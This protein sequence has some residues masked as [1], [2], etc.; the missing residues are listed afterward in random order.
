MDLTSESESKMEYN[1][2]A[3]VVHVCFTPGSC[4]SIYVGVIYV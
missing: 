3:D 2:A 4:T 1:Q